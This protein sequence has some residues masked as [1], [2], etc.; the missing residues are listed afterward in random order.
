MMTPQTIKSEL[1]RLVESPDGWTQIPPKEDGEYWFAH[2]KPWHSENAYDA[3]NLTLVR[4]KDGRRVAEMDGYDE[5]WRTPDCDELGNPVW[6]S[7]SQYEML[8]A[9]KPKCDGE[10]F[11]HLPT[12]PKETIFERR[13]GKCPT[14]GQR[15]A[16][17]RMDGCNPLVCYLCGATGQVAADFFDKQFTDS[18]KAA[19]EADV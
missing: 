4:V 6:D 8:A 14:C 3:D 1:R 5:R 2:A 13:V 11:N 15:A 7:L 9:W 19:L 16:I 18:L 10:N 12:P 17:Y